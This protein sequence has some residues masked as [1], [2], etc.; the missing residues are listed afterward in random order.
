MAYVGVMFVVVR[1]L[2]TRLAAR[3]TRREMPRRCG[4]RHLAVLPRIELDP[5]S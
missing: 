4:G 5:P 1:P 3:I 2:F